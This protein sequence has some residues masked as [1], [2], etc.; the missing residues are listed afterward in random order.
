MH[1]ARAT[2]KFDL[3]ET[4]SQ[5]PA[6]ATINEA[7]LAIYRSHEPQANLSNGYD[8]DGQIFC[9]PSTMDWST[10]TEGFRD[11]WPQIVNAHDTQLGDTLN[12]SANTIG[13]LEFDVTDIVE[14][15]VTNPSENFGFLFRGFLPGSAPTTWG[16]IGNTAVFD[17]PGHSGIL[18]G[19]VSSESSDT[20][21]RPK[22]TVTFNSSTAV[23]DKSIKT[24]D[25]GISFVLSDLSVK[26]SGLK[27]SY[28]EI[29][30]LSI[31]GRVLLKQNVNQESIS[32]L[33]PNKANQVMLL[34]IKNGNIN[35]IKKLIRK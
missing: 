18:G 10:N 15:M 3:S 5:I 12:Y 1:E 29:S 14:E 7:T 35:M 24:T 28:T 26:I 30:L 11:L 20:E 34:Q 2:V 25:R 9:N 13:W 19:Y 17:T 33:L 6:N 23:E 32:L 22:L 31:N 16:T 27:E 21:N 8:Q 4:V